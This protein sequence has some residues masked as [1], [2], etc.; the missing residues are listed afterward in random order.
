MSAIE[1]PAAETSSETSP[2]TAGTSLAETSLAVARA[3]RECQRKL[4]SAPG[5]VRDRILERLAALLE[6]RE[7]ELLAANRKD[8]E[9]AAAGDLAL[10]LLRRLE[11]TPAKLATLRQGVEQLARGADPIGRAVSR[12]ELDDGLLL[13]QV[14]SPIGV[15][16]IIFESRPDAVIQIGSLALRSGNGVVLKGGS[17][18]LYSNRALVDCLRA[19]VASEGLGADAVC[20]V[21][22]R[23][24][25]GA[26]L[27]HDELIDLVIPR[28]SSQ[29]VRSIQSSTR[30]PVLG[31]AD[32]ICHLVLDAA[33][34]PVTAKKLAVDGKCD[35]PAACNATETLLVHRDF[36]PHLEGVAGALAA[37][38]VELR[39]DARALP[40]CPGAVAATQDDWGA[41]YGDLVLAVRTVDDL[42]E[43]IRHIH[44]Y[45]SAHTDAVVTLD[46]E[47]GRRFLDEVDSSSVFVN[48]STRFS[49]GYRYGLG[50]EVGIS[51]GRIH[52]RGPVG[53]EGLLTTRW[54]LEGTG[55][56]AADYGPGKRAFKH[57][58]LAGEE[59]M[60]APAGAASRPG[61]GG[62]GER[63]ATEAV[64]AGGGDQVPALLA[65]RRQ[66]EEL[67]A[68]E[69]QVLEMIATGVPLEASLDAVNRLIEACLPAT[70]SS[71]LLLD[72]ARLRLQHG[73][74]PSLPEA[75]VAAIDGLP[76]GPA[77][78]SCGTAAHL[79]R[80]VIVSDIATD[81][82]WAEFRELALRFALAACW[83]TPIR[84]SNRQVLGTFAVY[85]RERG[86]PTAADLEIIERM[87]HLAGIAIERQRADKNARELAEKLTF[88]ARHDALTGLYNRQWLERR[89]RQLL[90]D[91][92]RNGRQHALCYLDLDQFK[93][94]NDSCGHAM[95]DELLQ[96]LG[97]ELSQAVAGHDM[98]ARLGGDEF[99]VLFENCSLDRAQ[100]AA[101]AIRRAIEGFRFRFKGEDFSIGAS[102]GLVPIVQ[103]SGTVAGILRAADAA[104]YAAKDGG[105]RRIHTFRPDDT[106]LL[107]RSGEMRWVNRIRLALEEDRFCLD[108]QP[109]VNLHGPRPAGAFFEL[110]LRME[111]ADGRRFAPGEFLGAAERYDL[112]TLLD[113]WVLVAACDWLRGA[114]RR[115]DQVGR[116]SINL[117]GQSLADRDFL[118]FVLCQLEEK[119]IPPEKICFEITETAAIADLSR[120]TRFI[121]ALRSLGCRF[122]LDDFGTGFSSFAYLK[123]LPVDYLKIDGIFVVGVLEKRFDRAVVRSI[124]ELSRLVG[125]KTIA[126]CVENHQVLRK[127]EQ[128]GVDYAQGYA[129]GRPRPLEAMALPGPALALGGVPNA[130]PPRQL[131]LPF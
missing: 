97:T 7:D 35:Y 53:V 23:A 64:L 118:R 59:P 78:G 115:L 21:E 43:A 33:A 41:E 22:G 52:A 45:G 65:D 61:E 68:G 12:T 119:Q 129:V 63:V 5:E 2:A 3:V 130:E 27:E 25:A 4:G 123:S 6:E 42:G 24:A 39:A 93:I 34:D 26:L 8:L 72:A 14:S 46:D 112:A 76:I 83:S 117:S 89:L 131:S 127:L 124:V 114:P 94:I 13:R 87:T 121:Q 44:R 74:A 96:R 111:T 99:G 86:E 104:C 79:G 71:V 37:A 19:A 48:V 66:M 106:E 67:L 109:I 101:D 54:L 32:G 107:R 84:S 18:A 120:A 103:S 17:E 69:K 82:L 47:A 55:Q 29:L 77:A 92:R 126:E 50:A 62:R 75:Y 95:G 100:Q 38:G 73:S 80:Q 10:P 20:G 40:F 9:A 57:R 58:R 81:P 51:T 125:M 110:L 85:R 88:Q 36:L 128:L 116:C 56:G 122:A 49:D 60:T 90:E 102:I 98:L 70:L 91:A 31:H 1:T 28:G 113:R 30:V 11:L 105:R 16:L 108:G 15:L